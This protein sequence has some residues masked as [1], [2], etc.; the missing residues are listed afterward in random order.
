MQGRY[1]ANRPFGAMALSVLCFATFSGCQRSS[2]DGGQVTPSAGTAPSSGP[3]ALDHTLDSLGV[4]IG[5]AAGD[6]SV[7]QS[8]IALKSTTSTLSTEMLAVRTSLKGLNAF[9]K[10]SPKDCSGADELLTALKRKTDAATAVSAEA[11]MA[12][13]VLDTA[14]TKL[15]S[16]SD[17]LATELKKV[18]AEATA[19]QVSIQQSQRIESY[20]TAI[21]AMT[22]LKSSTNLSVKNAL[23]AA[24][25]ADASS[26][27]QA[28]AGQKVVN[29]CRAQ[30]SAR[31][32]AR[33]EAIAK[34]KAAANAQQRAEA[35]ARL[36]A[37]ANARQKSDAN[38]RRKAEEIARLKAAAKAASRS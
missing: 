8:A 23:T 14:A 29:Q 13:A 16:V 21:Q 2:D 3:T 34:A 15:G 7:R 19:G 5:K 6:Q 25:D 35:N 10:R 4:R 30:A 24:S 1:F 31:E 18:S 27:R 33:R 37:Q 38:A 12:A 36:K 17:G 20:N 22:A 9:H 32:Q 11:K 28:A 26:K